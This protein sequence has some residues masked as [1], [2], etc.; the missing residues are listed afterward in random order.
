MSNLKTAQF[1]TKQTPQQTLIDA[2]ENGS[3]AKIAIV[4][5]LDESYYIHTS[6]SDGSLLKRLGMLEIAKLKMLDCAKEE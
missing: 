4:V 6:W 3:K 1:G 5:Y 2:L